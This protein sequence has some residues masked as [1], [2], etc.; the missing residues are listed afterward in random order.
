M[1]QTLSVDVVVC[2]VLLGWDCIYTLW[3][4]FFSPF[5]LHFPRGYVFRAQ[6]PALFLQRSSGHNSP[7]CGWLDLGQ[8]AI[9]SYVGSHLCIKRCLLV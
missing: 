4:Y 1:R 3:M 6:D 8:L 7:V 5:P 2:I 9:V